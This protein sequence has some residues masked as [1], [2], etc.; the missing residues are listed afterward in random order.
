VWTIDSKRWR[1]TSDN[2]KGEPLTKRDEFRKKILA[3]TLIH[4]TK[5]ESVR[6]VF[7][8]L[9]KIYGLPQAIRSDNGPPFTSSK[10]ML[11]LSSLSA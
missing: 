9:F 4:E 8:D 11:G 3:V 6:S 2:K 1:R 10:E 7:E 5:T